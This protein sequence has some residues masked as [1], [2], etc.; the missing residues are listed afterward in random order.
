MCPENVESVEEHHAA[1]TSN[2]TIEGEMFFRENHRA[3]VGSLSS[4]VEFPSRT[5][6]QNP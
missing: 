3:R 5:L 4:V 6:V 2:T 1:E